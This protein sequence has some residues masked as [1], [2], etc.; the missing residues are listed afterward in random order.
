MKRFL[1]LLVA[2]L[3]SFATFAA[4]TGTWRAYPAYTEITQIETV[5]NQYYV[6]ASNGLYVYNR[7]DNSTRTFDKTNVLSDCTIKVIGWNRGARKLVI[8]YQNGN[9]D[10]LSPNGNVEN[11]PDYF[12]KNMT[13]DKTVNSLTNDGSYAYLSTAFGIV[14]INVRNAEISE[15]YTLDANVEYTYVSNG[16]LYAGIPAQGIL[17]GS[18]TDNLQDKSRWTLVAPYSLRTQ[19]LDAA[20]IALVSRAKPDAPKYNRFAFMRFYGNKLYTAGGGYRPLNDALA[21]GAIQVWDGNSWQIFQDSL[22]KY[23]PGILYQDITSV[24][25]DPA[26][27]GHAFASGR[28][29][30][31]EF[32]NGQFVKH[33]T[34]DNSPLQPALP[35]DK[36]Y[37]L[38]LSVCFDA[39]SNLWCLNSNNAAGTSLLQLTP[40][41]TWNNFSQSQL[42]GDGE[43]FRFLTGLTFDSRCLLWFV[44]DHWENRSL[45]CYHPATG[46]LKR[47]NHF[48]D[49]DGAALGEGRVHCVAEDK[50][51]NMWIGTG[52][53][54]LMLSVAQINASADQFTRIKVPRNDGTNYADYLLNG[55]DVNCIAVDGANR[56]WFGTNGNGVYLISAD[57]LK[58]IHHFTAENSSLLS[59]NVESIA[60]NDATGEVFFGTDQGLCSFA[61]DATQP[62]AQMNADEV[63]A[64]P[65]PVTPGYTGLVTVR[66]LSFNADVK[67]A[68]AS[69]TL[70]AQGRSNGGTFVW[71]GNDLAGRRVASGV[72]M[73]LVA[74]ENGESGVVAKIAVVR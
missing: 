39:Q 20:D 42:I 50:Q 2:V 40:A 17:A 59:N 71:D 73:V 52:N 44:N 6:L 57:N 26:D 37:V 36:N 48:V 12:F 60:I 10:L 67:I 61:G 70:V 68:T 35:N 24:A 31:Y 72:Y 55:V 1:F 13:S 27:A 43:T 29:G 62:A 11:L 23:T 41:G 8:V 74:T 56:K 4:Q 64:F 22:Q 46:T 21:P 63:Y 25:V 19:T 30:V 51:Q 38:A 49:Q 33:Y 16:K 32:R 3:V 5:G 9:I 18:L 45:L 69:G 14:K 58:Q 15:T 34:M 54:P 47:Y 53:G 7:A 66:G 65:N 28:T